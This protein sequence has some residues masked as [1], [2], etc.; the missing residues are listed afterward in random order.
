MQLS[1]DMID[2]CS[3]AVDK[4]GEVIGLRSTRKDIDWAQALFSGC[5]NI[6]D[7]IEAGKSVDCDQ[8][9]S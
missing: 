1:W 4:F 9:G 8:T 3:L 5:A 2:E 6:D 7:I